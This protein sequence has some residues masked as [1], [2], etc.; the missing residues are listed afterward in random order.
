[1][2]K[3]FTKRNITCLLLSLILPALILPLR[4]FGMDASQSLL[5]A[6]LVLVVFWWVVNLLPKWLSSLFLLAIFAIFGRTP[7][8]SVFQFPLSDNFVVILFA[9]LFSQGIANSGLTKR[10]LQPL[11][12]RWIHT[13]VQFLLFVIL[14]N[15]ALIFVIPQPF[16]RIIL[17]AFITDE[18]LEDVCPD[19]KRRGI[20]MFAVFLFSMTSNMLFLR[21]DIIMNYAVLSFGEVTLTES[22]WAAA[23]TVPTL[24][25]ILAELGMLLIM[26]RNSLL[27]TRF[28]QAP[29][30]RSSEKLTGREWVI[31]AVIAATM[32][33]MATESLHGI[34]SKW[35]ILAST[36]IMFVLG[37]LKLSDIR[38]INFSLLIW[39]TAAFSI[40]NV[41]R[42]SG[43]ADII[44]SRLSVL[45]PDTFDLLFLLAV[46]LITMG[47]H[48]V[49]GGS[50]TTTSVVIPGIISIA[51]GK[52]P[53]AMLILIIYILVYN[54]FLLPIHN[55]VLVIGNGDKRFPNSVVM[56]YGGALTVLMPLFALFV[57]RYWWQ[58]LDLF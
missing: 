43:T 57:Y 49:L 33:L 20:L 2:K 39:L 35:V 55:A 51:A 10:L 4:P 25:L 28:S 34:S 21:G 27:R 44:F 52:A 58:L 46:V 7:L 18:F 56:Q 24:L 54:H 26:Y 8:A 12:Y 23:M 50:V 9:F 38:S 1:M 5:F 19:E 40:G 29:I 6:S 37:L 45:F 36:V 22:G 15:I 47:L 14:C 11:F 3:L 31:L 42:G 16:A 48:M 17:F 30:R 41:M 53:A 32:L 13:P